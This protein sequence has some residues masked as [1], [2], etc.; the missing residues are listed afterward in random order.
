LLLGQATLFSVPVTAAVLLVPALTGVGAAFGADSLFGPAILAFFETLSRRARFV[1]TIVA[2]MLGAWGGAF[3]VRH[4]S[5]NMLIPLGF[6]GGAFLG[7]S[8][9]SRLN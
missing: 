1:V 5:L 7:A 9:A 3:L 6:I 2:I 8:L 4:T